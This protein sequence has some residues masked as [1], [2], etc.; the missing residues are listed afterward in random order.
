MGNGFTRKEATTVLTSLN[1]L[2][3]GQM[4]DTRSKYVHLKAVFPGF[5]QYTDDNTDRR[6]WRLRTLRYAGLMLTADIDFNSSVHPYPG[7]NFK[8]W[9]RW[10]TWLQLMPGRADVWIDSAHSDDPPA[11]AIMETVRLAL[12]DPSGVV[13]FDWSEV[14]GAM[15]VEI[16]RAGAPNYEIKVWSKEEHGVPGGHHDNDEDDLP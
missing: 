14:N 5:L 11:K 8:R 4:A 10:L 16:K 6:V 3:S 9:L 2:F 12:E 13:A 7:K 15:R 1:D